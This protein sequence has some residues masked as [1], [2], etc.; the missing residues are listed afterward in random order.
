MIV[1]QE[2][3]KD[4]FHVLESHTP[5]PITMTYD[6]FYD[7]H[8]ETENAIKEQ[9]PDY[10]AELDEVKIK[11]AYEQ[12]LHPT[13]GMRL[14]KY[15]ISECEKVSG[16]LDVLKKVANLYSAPGYKYEPMGETQA[17]ISSV[18]EVAINRASI[19]IAL[20]SHRGMGNRLHVHPD[21]IDEVKKLMVMLSS[22]YEFVENPYV[23]K[24]KLVVLYEGLHE[25]DA[26]LILIDGEY[27][28][29]HG[30]ADK[31]GH[32]IDISELP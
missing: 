23:D 24:D 1:K 8:I 29:V 9:V 30:A 4:K 16:E 7:K 5:T 12:A 27:M 14:R 21:R 2:S 31:Y 20:E 13:V 19:A 28:F 26:P 11:E 15:N 3:K 10:E 6:E 32:C 25:S 17:D 18:L 22:T